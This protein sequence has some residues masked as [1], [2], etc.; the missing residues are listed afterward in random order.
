[1][2]CPAKKSKIINISTKNMVFCRGKRILTTVVDSTS[3]SRSRIAFLKTLP[4]ITR[5]KT[6][7]PAP[8]NMTVELVLFG[9][10]GDEVGAA[11]TD[12]FDI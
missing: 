2:L 1:M 4:Q 8:K 7:A 5:T 10:G 9:E 11:A 12:T 3:K 6:T